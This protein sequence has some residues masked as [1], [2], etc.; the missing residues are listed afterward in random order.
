MNM[1]PD[2]AM[3]LAAGLGTRMRPLTLDLPKPLVTIAGRALIDRVLDGLEKTPVKQV[4]VN[5]HHLGEKVQRHLQAQQASRPF[6]FIFSDESNQLL[7]SGGGVVKALPLLGTKPFFILNTDT[8]WQEGMFS[9]LNR[10]AEAFHED[11]M[12]MLLLTVKG[13]QAALPERGDFFM[14]ADGLLT[15][16]PPH[17]PDAVI[18]AG[19]MMAHPTIFA[20]GDLERFPKSGNRFSDKKRGENKGLERFAEPS[21]AKT[22]LKPH[23]LNM[24]FDRAITGRRLYGLAL[25]GQWYTVGTMAALA[26]VEACHR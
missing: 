14:D 4:V 26:A 12:D 11:K 13:E 15:R 25:Q 20:Q 7:D 9:N 24:Y 22:A 10:L 21:E 19:A 2:C 16:A 23:S 8:F 17:D 3:L 1:L 5:L 6:R 18:Y